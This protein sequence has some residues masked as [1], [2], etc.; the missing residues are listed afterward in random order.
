MTKELDAEVTGLRLRRIPRQARSRE[1]VGR[2]LEAAE[3]LLAA[4]GTEALTTTRVAAEAGVSVG[5]LYQ[6][7]PDRDVIIDALADRYLTKLEALMDSF[8]DRAARESWPDPAAVLVDS[9]AGLYR[10]EPGFRALWFGRHL[11]EQTRD[12]DRR[13]KRVMATGLH[14]ILVAQRLLP[15]DAAA[16]TATYAAFLAADAVIQEAFRTDPEG[17]PELLHQL[18]IMLRAYLDQLLG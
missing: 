16:E 7:L 5:A 18:K 2:M 12:A 11:T 14:C 4:E 3:R 13:H 17:N 15:A 9:F 6:Y 8:V 10:A 1:K